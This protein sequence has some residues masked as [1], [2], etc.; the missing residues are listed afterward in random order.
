MFLELAKRLCKKSTHKQHHHAC[1]V[2]IG[3]AIVAVGYNH[4][5]THA[6]INALKKLWPNHRKNVKLY[7]FRFSKGG[8]WA[9]AKPCIRCEKFIRD[10]G[11]KIV[12][13]T[14]KD[15]NLERMKL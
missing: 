7:S 4:E 12:Y 11:V 14:D 10:S 6:E 1:V 8:K 13:Y 5:T 9:M 2:T 3:G 15:G